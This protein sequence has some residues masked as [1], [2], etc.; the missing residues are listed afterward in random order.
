MFLLFNLFR[1]SVLR[2]SNM[3]IFLKHY[4]FYSVA[5]LLSHLL[6]FVVLT[7]NVGMYLFLNNIVLSSRNTALD[8]TKGDVGRSTH[9]ATPYMIEVSR[10]E[11]IHLKPVIW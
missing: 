10:S 9:C 5:S 1:I 8:L 4:I 3:L 11:Q 6:I 2:V 7:L